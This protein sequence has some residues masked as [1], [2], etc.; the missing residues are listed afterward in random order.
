MKKKSQLTSYLVERSLGTAIASLFSL[1]VSP[2][3]WAQF[4]TLPKGENTE[5]FIQPRKFQIKKKNFNNT[6]NLFFLWNIR[7]SEYQVLFDCE[8]KSSKTHWITRMESRSRWWLTWNDRDE[9]EEQ[10]I[11][12]NR[13]HHRHCL[14]LQALLTTELMSIPILCPDE[15]LFNP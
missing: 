2:I 7:I 14:N 9:S 8:I 4:P 11:K 6:T 5:E 1:H 12:E 13:G 15:W 3:Q 10:P